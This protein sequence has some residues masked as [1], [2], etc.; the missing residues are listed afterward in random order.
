MSFGERLKEVR[1]YRG[2]TQ[3][4]LADGADVKKAVISLYENGSRY[5]SFEVLEAL[6]DT[7]NINISY[8][9]GESDLSIPEIDLI[10]HFRMSTDAGKAAISAFADATSK[11]KY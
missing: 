9:F 3:T 1:Q 8:L 7:L 2:M 11:G 5:P 4:E 6:A 10:N